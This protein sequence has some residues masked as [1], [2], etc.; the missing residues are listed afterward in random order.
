MELEFEMALNLYIDLRG[1]PIWKKTPFI[2]SVFIRLKFF[3]LQVFCIP[4][5]HI[6]FVAVNDTIFIYCVS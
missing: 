6:V 1:E 5:Y 3:L 4:R 2:T